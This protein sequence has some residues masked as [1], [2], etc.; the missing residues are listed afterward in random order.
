MDQDQLRFDIAALLERRQRAIDLAQASLRR[1]H[2]LFQYWRGDPRNDA[3]YRL[4]TEQKRVSEH[5][6]TIF[7]AANTKYAEAC[8]K[9][10]PESEKGTSHS[11]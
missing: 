6:I 10:L 4:W 7:D 11:A 5:A 8:V 2:E 9:I 3:K 1:E